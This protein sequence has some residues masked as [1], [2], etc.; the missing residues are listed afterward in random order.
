MNVQ[1]CRFLLGFVGLR[2]VKFGGYYLSYVF[3]VFFGRI[4]IYLWISHRI[5]ATKSWGGGFKKLNIG[6]VWFWLYLSHSHYSLVSGI[7][8]MYALVWS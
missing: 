1:C 4:A 5:L 3:L 7:V 2:G 6:C 8:M